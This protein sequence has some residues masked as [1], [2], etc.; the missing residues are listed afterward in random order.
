MDNKS[1]TAFRRGGLALR[2]SLFLLLAFLFIFSFAFFYTLEFTRNILEN[3]AMQLA[4]NVTDLTIS[5]ITNVIR[6]VE[7]VP[8]ALAPALESERPDYKNIQEIAK[9]FVRE[10]SL[11]FGTALAFEPYMHDAKHYRYCPYFFESRNRIIQKD[12]ASPE[13]DYF[14]R[15]WYR[16]PKIL[17]TPVWS[18][19]YYD[20]GGGDTMMCTYS[21]PFYRE[22]RGNR[23]FAGVITM[24]ISLQSFNH[25]LNSA[26]VYQTGFSFLVSRRGKF[27]TYPQ[28]EYVNTDILDLVRKNGD[29]RALKIAERMLK[30]ERLF[31]E[32]GNLEQRQLPSLIYFAPVPMTG[33]IFALTFPTQELYS[34]LYS[35]FKKLALI[36]SLSLFAMI[37]F[38]VLI[39][40]KFTRPISKLVDATR[41][42]GQGDFAADIPVYR[43]R[44][45]IE[46]L[47]NAFSVMK[48]DLVNYIR[49]LRESTI[50]KEKIEGE[51]KIARDIQ[52]GMIPTKFPAFPDRKEFDIYGFIEPA[53]KVG[54]DL[55]DF[56]FIDDE[57]L[58]FAIGDVAGKGTPAALFM[59]ITT[60]ILRAETQIAGLNVSKVIELMNNYLCKNNDSNLFVTLFLGILNT[61]KGEVEYVNAGHN[62]PFII[63]NNGTVSEL[64]NTHCIPLGITSN[65]CRN[66]T[67]FNLD[68]GDT[69]FL[70]TDGISEAFNNE[71]QQYS[72]KRINEMLRNNANHAPYEIV[73]RIVDDVNEFS[74]GIEQSDDIS[75]LAIQYFGKHLS[76]ETGP[77]HQIVI[78]NSEEN[79]PLLAEKIMRLCNDLNIPSGSTYKVNLVV[80]ELISNT[81]TLGYNDDLQHDIILNF[82]F[83]VESISIEIIDDA[84]EF[85]PVVIADADT[86][87][88]ISERKIGGM[89]IHLVKN[90][91]DAF[92]Y[93][94]EDTKNITKIII[95]YS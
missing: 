89:G 7:Q 52:M 9:D 56:F 16:I 62:F 65:S 85:N 10:D 69:I 47:S 24:D 90:L 39:T 77:T 88:E 31:T 91:T 48:E 28:G 95:R 26:K 50:E 1:V 46:Q 87:S 32:I 22:F 15:D 84:K 76:K 30:G 74:H 75:V 82:Q 64:K 6:P 60:T 51:L 14:S 73:N 3:D 93:H 92:T 58:C 38:S 41:R 5:R 33:W 43:S 83:D 8:N 29:P 2:Y 49:N 68:H 19:P 59:A 61:S 25:I 34:G 66:Q 18:E 71:D 23:T 35:F 63:K 54:G 42:I 21:V 94:R 79:L 80:E 27:I 17:G 67:T 20:K 4:S 11:T 37:I 53:K 36:F 86:T 13:Y 40:R 55:Y 78:P 12:L 81:I 70:Y 44:D 45:E 72:I 57:R